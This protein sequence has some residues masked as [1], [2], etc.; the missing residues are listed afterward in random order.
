[1]AEEQKV[2]C[3]GDLTMYL[4]VRTLYH[5]WCYFSDAVIFVFNMCVPF[6]GQVT[7]TNCNK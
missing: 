7:N 1:M 5:D 4:V 3:Q 6:A 2:R